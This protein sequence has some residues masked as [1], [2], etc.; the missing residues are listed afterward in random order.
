MAYMRNL[1]DAGSAYLHG[2]YMIEMSFKHP[3]MYLLWYR[4]WVPSLLH[5]D[6]RKRLRQWMDRSR[7]YDY[8][9]Y[10]AEFSLYHPVQFLVGLFLWRILQGIVKLATLPVKIIGGLFKRTPKN[11][12][13]QYESN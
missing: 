7:R 5:E 12:E 13:T 10:W 3:I 6:E 2:K 9:P 8:R 11:E 1:F 4:W